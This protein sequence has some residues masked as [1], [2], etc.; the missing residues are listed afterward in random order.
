MVAGLEP[1]HG[2]CS[3]SRARRASN[4]ANRQRMSTGTRVHGEELRPPQ[5]RSVGENPC[6]RYGRSES[7]DASK[8]GNAVRQKEPKKGQYAP[9]QGGARGNGGK[10]TTSKVPS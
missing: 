1:V 10:T 7:S 4:P 6:M 5:G 9:D 3:T 8:V 2:P